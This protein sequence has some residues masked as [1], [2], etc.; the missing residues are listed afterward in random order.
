MI[1]A[2]SVGMMPRIGCETFMTEYYAYHLDSQLVRRPP[3]CRS[4]GRGR[5]LVVKRT[6]AAWSRGAFAAPTRRFRGAGA[7]LVPDI[8]TTSTG[9]GVDTLRRPGRRSWR[10]AERGIV[11]WTRH[12]RPRSLQAPPPQQPRRYLARTPPF[13]PNRSSPI[14]IWHEVRRRVAASATQPAAARPP[15]PTDAA[16]RVPVMQTRP[17]PAT[18]SSLRAARQRGRPKRR[19]RRHA[20]RDPNRAGRRSGW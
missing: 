3:N 17:V 2:S 7:A 19:G 9:T 18:R 1:G 14:D 15:A 5:S 11:A 16:A 13:R 20:P 6:N 8:G 12:R 10:G 4:R